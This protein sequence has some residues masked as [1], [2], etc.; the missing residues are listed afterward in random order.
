MRAT[1]FKYNNKEYPIADILFVKKKFE[2]DDMFTIK[3]GQNGVGITNEL[4]EIGE[5]I[6]I[7]SKEYYVYLADTS[8]F[9]AIDDVYEL[10]VLIRK[11]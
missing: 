3:F 5:Y 10:K 9:D 7:L 1:V 11:R 6:N 4:Q 8:F 2:Q